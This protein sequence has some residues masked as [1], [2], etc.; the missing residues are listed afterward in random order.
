MKYM[1]V[2][3]VLRMPPKVKGNT[4]CPFFEEM[5]ALVNARV[6]ARRLLGLCGQILEG[7]RITFYEDGPLS[8]APMLRE[9]Y[10]GG[11]QTV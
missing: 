1:Y 9:R 10:A 4:L 5:D 3:N 7:G 2:Y 6:A 11:K 8:K